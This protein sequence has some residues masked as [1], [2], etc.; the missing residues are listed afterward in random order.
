MPARGY[1]ARVTIKMM[2]LAQNTVK[3]EDSPTRVCVTTGS[4]IHIG[5]GQNDDVLSPLAIE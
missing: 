3:V 4:H 5:W 1:N 2:T